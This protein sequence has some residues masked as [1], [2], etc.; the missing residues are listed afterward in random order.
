MSDA[1]VTLMTRFAAI[2]LIVALASPAFADDKRARINYMIQCQGCHLP[3]ATGTPGKVPP[4]KDFLGFFLHSEEGRS[5]IIRVP[6]VTSASLPNDELAELMN[7][8]LTTYS[9][10]ELPD[11]FEPYSAEELGARRL[12]I[13][14]DPA[15]RRLEILEEIAKDLPAL[16]ARFAEVHY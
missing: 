4:M 12:D 9:A 5:Y 8:L 2:G 7:W 6:G 15:A 3:E 16:K 10:E 14:A 1:G 11:D 13:V